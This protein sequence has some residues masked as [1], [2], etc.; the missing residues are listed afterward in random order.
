MKI[1]KG[2]RVV[3]KGW[4]NENKLVVIGKYGKRFIFKGR[5]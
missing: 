1:S 3:L 4:R 2:T 5:C